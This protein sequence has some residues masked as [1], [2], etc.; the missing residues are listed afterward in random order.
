MLVYVANVSNVIFQFLQIF[1][2]QNLTFISPSLH[3]LTLA[4]SL[5]PISFSVVLKALI[6]ALYAYLLTYS[7]EQSPS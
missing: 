1:L 3:S 2:T 4:H 5:N 7:M 6:N